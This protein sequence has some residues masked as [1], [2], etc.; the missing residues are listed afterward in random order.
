MGDLCLADGPNG[1]TCTRHD[2][3]HDTHV[4]YLKVNGQLQ[5]VEWFA[6]NAIGEPD[7]D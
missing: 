4:A 3:D 5:H 1:L 2:D 7:D 6:C